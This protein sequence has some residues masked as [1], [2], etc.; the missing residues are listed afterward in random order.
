[1]LENTKRI[2]DYAVFVIPRVLEGFFDLFEKLGYVKRVPYSLSAL[3][4]IGMALLLVVRKCYPDIMP[5]T[6]LGQVNFIFG[7]NNVLQEKGEKVE[8][9]HN[10]K[11]KLED[12]GV[13]ITSHQI[14]QNAN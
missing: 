11:E 6:Y 12:D 14:I 3:F 13:K 1:M 10:E 2:E 5:S 7:T 9:K 8:I 4:A